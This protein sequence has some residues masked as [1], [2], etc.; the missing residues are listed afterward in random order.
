[1]ERTVGQRGQGKEKAMGW[2]AEGAG[3]SERGWEGDGAVSE[4]GG[5]ESV[6][7]G[8]VWVWTAGDA[9]VRDGPVGLQGRA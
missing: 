9:E 1:M 7:G 3:A 2:Q 8:G 6:R 4:G 5:L